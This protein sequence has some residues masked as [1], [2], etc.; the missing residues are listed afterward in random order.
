MLFSI[1]NTL[2]KHKPYIKA[3]TLIHHAHFILVHNLGHTTCSFS[4]IYI[5]LASNLFLLTQQSGPLAYLKGTFLIFYLNKIG[6]P[7]I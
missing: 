6:F 5:S 7:F 1:E 4:F 3:N 2:L